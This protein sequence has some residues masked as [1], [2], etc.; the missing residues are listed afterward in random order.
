MTFFCIRRV[1]SY[2][3]FIL[4][5]FCS[6]M[7]CLSEM[8]RVSLSNYFLTVLRFIETLPWLKVEHM[9]FSKFLEDSD[10]TFVSKYLRLCLW[11]TEVTTFSS[12]RAVFSFGSLYLLRWDYDC[13]WMEFILR[14]SL[15]WGNYWIF[16]FIKSEQ[17]Y[18]SA[19]HYKRSQTIVIIR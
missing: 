7:E 10:S 15:N 5:K 11:N 9:L 18:I 6:L 13:D 19:F 17:F 16:F 8:R 14:E 3:L 12:Y 4:L 2:F 1:L